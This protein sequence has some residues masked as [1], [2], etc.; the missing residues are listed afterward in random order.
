MVKKTF[1]KYEI[2]GNLSAEMGC[3]RCHF[4]SCFKSCGKIE[5]TEKGSLISLNL[6]LENCSD[7][8]YKYQSKFPQAV[9]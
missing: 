8:I 5:I 4:I 6:F 7:S 3:N 1:H 9:E 2:Y